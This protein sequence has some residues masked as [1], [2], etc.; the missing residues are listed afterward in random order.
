MV[1]EDDREHDAINKIMMYDVVLE[2]GSNHPIHR[3]VSGC[4]VYPLGQELPAEAEMRG[5]FQFSER[6]VPPPPRFT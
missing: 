4:Q 1:E 6:T 2:E 3:S 5:G